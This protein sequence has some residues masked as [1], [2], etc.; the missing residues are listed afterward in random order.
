[1]VFSAQIFTFFIAVVCVFQLALALGAPWGDLA[2][3]GRFPGR[4]PPRI[5]PLCLVQ[6]V[7]LMGMATIV[8]ARAGLILPSWHKSVATLAWGVVAFSAFANFA[9]PS[10]GE[11]RLWGPV[12]LV[13]LVTSFLVARS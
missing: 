8:D 5:R 13:L 7:L 11:R 1:M 4:L 12:S 10:P 6:I 2:M 9:T 3:G